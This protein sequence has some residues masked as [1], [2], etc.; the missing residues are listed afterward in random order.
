MATLPVDE[1]LPRFE[2][3]EFE[4]QPARNTGTRAKSKPNVR[5]KFLKFMGVLLQ[6]CCGNFSPTK[7]DGLGGADEQGQLGNSAVEEGLS[8]VPVPV[9]TL[10]GVKAIAAGE[11]HALALL[12]GGTV[13]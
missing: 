2:A 5:R 7:R 9:A 12:G 10:T 3:L 6:K 1:L 11:E 4:L 8:D 13:M